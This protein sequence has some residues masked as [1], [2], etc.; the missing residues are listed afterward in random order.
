MQFLKKILITLY[1][2]KP[3]N[4]SQHVEKNIKSGTGVKPKE[5]SLNIATKGDSSIVANIARKVA[6]I[7]NKYGLPP[8]LF[9]SNLADDLIDPEFAT[10]WDNVL[11]FGHKLLMKTC[12]TT[13]ITSYEITSKL[14]K[15]KYQRSSIILESKPL[16][17]K[18]KKHGKKYSTL[19]KNKQQ[20]TMTDAELAKAL[21]M[22]EDELAEAFGYT[23]TSG[24][25]HKSWEDVLAEAHGYTNTSGL[26]HRLCEDENY[27][28]DSQGLEFHSAG[29]LDTL[30]C[31]NEI[32]SGLQDDELAE[33]FGYSNVD[34]VQEPSAALENENS[35]DK[36]DRQLAAEFGYT[37][38]DARIFLCF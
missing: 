35:L 8:P 33:L 22:G 37:N 21:D 36:E 17:V 7:Q 9:R 2:V 15:R 23:N 27:E 1:Y 30:T 31:I 19:L 11:W 4:R 14:T 24:L 5:D 13:I 3:Y 18:S 16:R 28:I 6:N 32:N 25:N 20:N 34:A 12:D 29:E 38:E 10:L 26:S